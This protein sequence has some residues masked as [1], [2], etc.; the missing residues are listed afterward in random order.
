MD[1]NTKQA[2]RGQCMK[3]NGNEAMK[4]K[5]RIINLSGKM[6]TNA[7]PFKKD[8]TH[9]QCKCNANDIL[10]AAEVVLLL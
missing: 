1:F 2:T 3:C 6:N 9:H 4:R 7:N 8:G 5:Q 10:S